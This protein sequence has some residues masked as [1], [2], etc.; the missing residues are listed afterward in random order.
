MEG[1]TKKELCKPKAKACKI[2]SLRVG[3]PV[4]DLAPDVLQGQTSTYGSAV[5]IAPSTN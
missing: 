5:W 2:P 1:M 4:L 3:N